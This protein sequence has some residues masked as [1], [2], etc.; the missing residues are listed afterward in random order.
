MPK[1]PG[2]VGVF[3]GSGDR[4][5]NVRYPIAGAVS[6]QWRARGGCWHEVSGVTRNIGKEGAFIACKSPPP[7]GSPLKVMVTLPTRCGSYGAVCLYGTGKLRHVQRVGPLSEGFG[8]RMKFRLELAASTG[9]A[10]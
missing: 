1:T 2:Q 4:R 10:Q 6:F 9:R 3:A 5:R 7:V 8:A